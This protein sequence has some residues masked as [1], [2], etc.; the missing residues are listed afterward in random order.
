MMKFKEM[1]AAL[2]GASVLRNVSF[3]A[4]PGEL[5]ALVGPNG[6]GKTTL[7]KCAVALIPFSG[8]VTWN[9]EDISA[10]TPRE[11]ARRITYLPQGHVAY[12]PLPARD[13]V[14]IGREPSSSSLQRLSAEDEAA[15][16]AAMAQTHTTEF[17]TRP[18]TELSGG[19][20]ARVML[21]RALA[22]GAPVLLADEPTASLDPAHQLQVMALLREVAEEGRAVIAV[23]HD[24]LLAARFAHRVVVLDHGTVAAAGEPGE[25]LTKHVLLDVFGVESAEINLGGQTL[26]APLSPLDGTS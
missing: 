9:G 2:G 14:A 16:D 26:L 6:A 24:L 17:A 15:I 5:L 21:A 10:L 22:T 12:W 20:R 11:R 4:R 7:L 13:I 8:E 25:A 23:I 18:I 19:E 3:K 1:S